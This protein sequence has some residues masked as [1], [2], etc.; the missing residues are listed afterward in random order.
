MYIIN[1][2]LNTDQLEDVFSKAKFVVHKMPVTYEGLM[3]HERLAVL[4]L[5]EEPL[6]SVFHY[7]LQQNVPKGTPCSLKGCPGVLDRCGH[8]SEDCSQ[9]GTN[10]L[11]DIM[12]CKNCDS[13]SFPCPTCYCVVFHKQLPMYLD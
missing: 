8:C 4:P 5:L 12:Q 13:Y 7:I 11:D 10:V 1:K 2:M 3:G 6:Q 9:S